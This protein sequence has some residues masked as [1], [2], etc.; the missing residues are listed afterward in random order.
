MID[1]KNID[2]TQIIPDT[3]RDIYVRKL[4]VYLIYKIDDLKKTSIRIDHFSMSVIHLGY[5]AESHS[6]GMLKKH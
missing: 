2:V 4:F 6:Y 3:L 1:K 5:F